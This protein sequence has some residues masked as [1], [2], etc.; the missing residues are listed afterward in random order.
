MFFAL[1]LVKAGQ[2]YPAVLV[3]AATGIGWMSLLVNLLFYTV[4]QTQDSLQPCKQE[5]TALLDDDV[6]ALRQRLQDG[7]D[8]VDLH[9]PPR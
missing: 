9:L 6:D 4:N 1:L 5:R 3:L 7:Y 8:R 2:I